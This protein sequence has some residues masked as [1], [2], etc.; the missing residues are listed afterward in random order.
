MRQQEA[1]LDQLL[2]DPII[3]L[4][5]DRDGVSS[6][7]IRQLLLTRL[8]ATSR[9]DRRAETRSSEWATKPSR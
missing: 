8:M 4:L 5:M 1:T 2:C 6:D 9:V 3:R 7:T